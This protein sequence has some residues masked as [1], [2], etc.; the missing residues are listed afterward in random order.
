[1]ASLTGMR[2]GD[3]LRRAR[4]SARLSVHEL[5]E[6]TGLGGSTIRA[7]EN[8][9]NNI[10]PDIAEIYARSLGVP[11]EFLLFGTRTAAPDHEALLVPVVG[12]C[13][14]GI[15]A[16]IPEHPDD[17]SD[18]VP[19][20]DPAYSRASSVQALRVRGPSMN[21]C[22]RDGS[23]VVV[24]SVPEAGLVEGDHAVVRR[25]RHGLVETTLKE[26]RIGD[27]GQIELWPRSTDPKFQEPY[28]IERADHADDGIEIVAVVIA[29]YKRGPART[30]PRIL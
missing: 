2:P 27:Q 19:F 5:S 23:Y 8:N 3:R 1:M 26:V 11:P 21:E 17:P 13:A 4:L 29:A 24:V 22:Y 20:F 14:A 9:Q 25:S 12:D 16:E 6:R 28:I 10:K 15:F 7:H 30:G 18:F